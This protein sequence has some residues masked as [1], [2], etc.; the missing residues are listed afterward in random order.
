MTKQYLR[1]S[2]VARNSLIYSRLFFIGVCWC[3]Y[4]W[5]P[6]ADHRLIN[7]AI[8]IEII[9]Q[10]LSPYGQLST[11]VTVVGVRRKSNLLPS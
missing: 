5:E 11:M 6:D 10:V 7:A 3:G 8:R 1:P 9:A 4:I 2:V